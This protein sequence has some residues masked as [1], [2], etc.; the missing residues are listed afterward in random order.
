MKWV[1]MF[2]AAVVGCLMS[3]VSSAQQFNVALF[4]K[5]AGWHHDAIN[6]GVTTIKRLGELHNFNVFWTENADLIFKDEHLSKY[7]VVIFLLTTGDALNDEQQAA[8]ERFIRA[9]NGYVG[10]HSASDTEYKW[11]WY[12]K[13]VG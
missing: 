10:I 3:A 12:T 8:F 6:E 5:T 7:K 9:G 4:T 11:P 2:A 13:M 1:G